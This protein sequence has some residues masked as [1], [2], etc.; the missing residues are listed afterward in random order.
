MRSD[1]DF[2][3]EQAVAEIKRVDR[4]VRRSSRPAAVWWL[5]C[6]IATALY[7]SVMH[8]G[9]EPLETLAIVGWL[10]F[11]AVSAYYICRLGACARSLHRLMRTL[12]V[13][14]LVATVLNAAVNRYV[15]DG[16][17][18]WPVVVG[19]AG[20]L[21]AAVPPLYGGWRGLRELRDPEGEESATS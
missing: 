10:V 15:Y 3:A 12:T 20:I 7:W 17:G 9:V 14:F 4:E 16:E 11:T 1:S 8:F 13:V 19:V 6:G 5:A 21:L 18:G 2:R